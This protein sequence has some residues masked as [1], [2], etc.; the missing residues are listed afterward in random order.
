MATVEMT[1]AEEQRIQ[2]E[3]QKFKMPKIQVGRTVFWYDCA[4][5]KSDPK[6]AI[7]QKVSERS[8]T[9]RSIAPDVWGESIM[10]VPH[11][12]DPALWI[13]PNAPNRRRAA[14]GWDYSFFD[15]KNKEQMDLLREGI[16]ECTRWIEAHDMESA[17]PKVSAERQEI[18]NRLSLYNAQVNKKHSTSTLEK[19]LLEIEDA[20][21]A[22]GQD[23][24]GKSWREQIAERNPVEPNV[25]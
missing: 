5:S 10:S 7:V 19:Q 25:A 4:D 18:L 22:A 8:I 11:V 23:I 15:K 16:L 13:H 17:T 2:D 14:G 12:S 24:P 20:R 1:P 21:V 3:I 9:I 6:P